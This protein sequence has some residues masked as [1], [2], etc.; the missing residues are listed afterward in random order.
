[1]NLAKFTKKID[2]HTIP[3]DDFGPNV[4][5]ERVNGTWRIKIY[6]CDPDEYQPQEFPQFGWPHISVSHLDGEAIISVI[7]DTDKEA[8]RRALDFVRTE[9]PVPA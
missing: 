4:Y 8:M 6:R 2:R 7:G 1:M 5:I 3:V 9:T